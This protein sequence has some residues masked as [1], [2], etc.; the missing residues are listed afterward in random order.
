M[1]IGHLAGE[2]C[3]RGGKRFWERASQQSVLVEKLILRDTIQLITC[4]VQ[5]L[6]RDGYIL[7]AFT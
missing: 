3:D 6:V 1:C 5:G 4:G 2:R 7:P